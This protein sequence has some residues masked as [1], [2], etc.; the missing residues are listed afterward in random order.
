MEVDLTPDD[1]A[2]ISSNK[3]SATGME[4]QLDDALG[5]LVGIGCGAFL[6]CIPGALAYFEEAVRES[7]ICACGKSLTG[8]PA[9][10]KI[11]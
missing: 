8:A 2:V 10:D 11:D 9:R 3:P 5:L 7:A 4:L 1:Q 6:C